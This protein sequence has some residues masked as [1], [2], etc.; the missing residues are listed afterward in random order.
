MK[1]GRLNQI[2][3]RKRLAS[4]RLAYLQT[5][6]TFAALAQFDIADRNQ[7]REERL[8]PEHI[9]VLAKAVDPGTGE[10]RVL[11]ERRREHWPEPKPRKPSYNWEGVF[12]REKATLADR[13]SKYFKPAGLFQK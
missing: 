4:G 1:A 6:Q 2:T 12:L 5:L 9:A 13:L 11:S 3:Q 8:R 7:K 10:E